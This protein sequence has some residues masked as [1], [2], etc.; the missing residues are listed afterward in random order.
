MVPGDILVLSE[1]DR[2]PADGILLSS[3]NLS[4]DEALLTGE[5]VPVR[6]LAAPNHAGDTAD[7]PEMARPGGDDLPFVFSGTPVVRGSGIARAKATGVRTE[8]GK[9]GKSLQEVEQEPTLL[10]RDT[11]HLVRVLAFGG[12]ARCGLLVVVYGVTRG[13]WLR[14]FLA[15]LTLAMAILPEELP[16]VLTIFL[17]LG[18]WR[19]SRKQVLTRRTSAIEML[20]A[21]TAL[22]VDKT[23]TLTMDQMVVTRI[24]AQGETYDFSKQ[25]IS[26]MPDQFHELAEIA[27]LASQPD[28]FDPMDRA[29]RSLGEEA[30]RGTEHLHANWKMIREYPLAKLYVPFLR[31]LFHLSTLHPNDLGL[32]LLAGLACTAWFE[33]LKAIQRHRDSA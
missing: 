2:V 28:P 7:D 19:M 6:K 8:L 10:E 21:A 32:C 9:I 20:G 15:A 1:G 5:S 27:M 33:T 30:L 31:T 12:L 23:G 13:D 29:I 11:R 4:T 24:F 22:C 17:A 14:G 16:V 26:P 18:A 3:V 25:P